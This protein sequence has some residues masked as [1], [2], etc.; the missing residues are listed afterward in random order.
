VLSLGALFATGSLGVLGAQEAWRALSQVSLPWQTVRVTVLSDP[1]GA[2]VMVEGE[3]LG[4][5]PLELTL[6]AGQARRYTVSGDLQ[7]FA[8]FHGVLEGR[9]DLAVSVW[10][11]RRSESEQARLAA[12]AEAARLGD[13]AISEG[14]ALLSTRLHPSEEGRVIEAT[15]LAERGFGAVVATVGL[16]NEGLELVGVMTDSVSP[17]ESGESWTFFLPLTQLEV[18]SYRLLRLQAY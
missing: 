8:P 3:L 13:E 7:R 10:L 2:W 17:L 16:Y 6:P 18:A 4:Q 11:E 5:S 12:E 14:L 1:A 9:E 15:V